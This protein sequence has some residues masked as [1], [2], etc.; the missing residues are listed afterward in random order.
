MKVKKFRYFVGDFETTVYENQTFTE[1]WASASVEFGTE[2]VQIFHSISEQ[3]DYFKNI[4]GNICCYYH[5]LKF[6][7]TFWL[8][9]LLKDLQFK[10][11]SIKLNKEGTRYT[12]IEDKNMNNNSFKY[13]IS[14]LGQWYI[15]TIKVNDKYIVLRDSLKML[16][17]SVEELGKSFQTKHKKLN[18]E[19][20]GF[21]YSGCEITEEEKHYIANDVLVV[22]E[23]LEIMFS[24]GHKKITIGSCCLSEYRNLIGNSTF[25][26]L[27]PNLYEI[28][29]DKTIHK[30]ETAGKWILKSY[31]GGW[32]YLV[33]GKEGKIM[34]NGTTA[35]GYREF[36][37]AVVPLFVTDTLTVAPC[38]A[39]RNVSQF[40]L[41][42]NV[43]PRAARLLVSAT[44]FHP[45]LSARSTAYSL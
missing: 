27:F 40:Q 33:K 45:Q 43:Q 38:I 36:T 9:Y 19:Y 22:K 30:Y 26:K 41:L 32:C 37:S 28:P 39:A 29:L 20:E 23:A 31:R 34:H 18:M 35:D 13:M 10:Q 8:S 15:I 1:V 25:K 24:E 21:R 14:E 44:E 3:F 2:D 4:P 7:G 42:S 6:D 12:W 17:F 5:N 11:A 16:P